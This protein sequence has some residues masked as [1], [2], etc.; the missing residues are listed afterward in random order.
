[1]DL[2]GI[3]I[4]TVHKAACS[5]GRIS[6]YHVSTQLPYSVFVVGTKPLRKV[7]APSRLAY[8]MVYSTHAGYAISGAQ[9]SGATVQYF[10]AR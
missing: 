4:R 10:S 9:W 3:F 2:Q 1:V 7:P 5:S 8:S 6:R